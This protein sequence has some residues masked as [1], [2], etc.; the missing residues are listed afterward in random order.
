[1]FLL[2]INFT[3]PAGQV[4]YEFQLSEY[5]TYSSQTSEQV[6]VYCPVKAS[7]HCGITL[8]WG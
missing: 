3:R 1:M 4:L 6:K 2:K 7:K 8:S 5:K